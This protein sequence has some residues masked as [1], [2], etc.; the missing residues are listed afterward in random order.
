ME[1]I[2]DRLAKF[3]NSLN[4]SGLTPFEVACGFKLNTLGKADKGIN[5]S[6]LLRVLDKFPELN[7]DWVITGRGSMIIG[8]ISKNSSPNNQVFHPTNDVHH[9]QQVVIANWE[10]LRGVLQEVIKEQ[11]GKG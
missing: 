9:N 8:D 2:K 5:S 11:F 1:T 10:D 7:L 4:F 6:T 3:A